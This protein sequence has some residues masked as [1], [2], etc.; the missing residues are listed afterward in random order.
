[1]PNEQYKSLALK[2]EDAL[3]VVFNVPKTNYSSL[4][5]AMAYSVLGAGKRLRGVLLLEC[6]RICGVSVSNA[7]PFACALEMIHASTLIHDDLPCMDDDDFR[8]GKPSCHKEFGEDVALLAGD[9]L[10][11]FA[12]KTALLGC[13]DLDSDSAIQAVAQLVSLG[14]PDGVFGG[15]ILDK[16]YESD[17]CELNDLLELHSLKT[18][19][20]F[21]ACAKIPC[22]LGQTDYQTEKALSV[23]IR[24]L[25]VAFQVKDDILDV[26]GEFERLG[27]AIGADANKTTF[28][29]LLGMTKSKEYLS[30]LINEAKEAISEIKNNELLLW[31]CDFVMNRDL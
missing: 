25:G 9:A 5:D 16:K 7:M 21:Y 12:V 19:A 20:L 6:A 22:L 29:S 2:V 15:Q 31:I 11:A 24:K 14:G 10:Y 17:N 23:Y 3:N 26:E 4:Y 13:T 8:R 28:V 27:K 18:G 1:M 30:K